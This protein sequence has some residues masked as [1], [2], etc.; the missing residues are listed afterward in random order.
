MT[1]KKF[2]TSV[3]RKLKF[4]GVFTNFESFLPILYKYNLVSTLLYR[5]FV[6]YSS[7]TIL[8]FE[9]LKLK[10]IFWHNGYP[11]IFIYYCIKMYLDKA[12]I[13]H[14]NFGIAPKKDLVCVFVFLGKWSNQKTTAKNYWKNFNISPS[15]IVN[16]F[17][18]KDMLPKKLSFAI[19]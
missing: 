8:H 4:S 15:K 6:I 16:H 14:L 7:Y 18:F 2:Q 9:I 17:H 12:L 19:V 13:K 1:V 11:K 3:Y 10:Q 5:G